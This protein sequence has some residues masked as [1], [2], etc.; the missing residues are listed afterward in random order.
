[1]S[2]YTPPVLY[3]ANHPQRETS[4]RCNRC[5]KPICPDCAVLTPTGYRCKECVRGMQKIY[6]TAT[7]IDFVLAFITALVLSYIGS[8]ITGFLGF[9]ILLLAPLVG[10]VIAEA[11]RYVIRKRRSPGLY[12]TAAIATALGSLP[13]LVMPVLT[14]IIGLSSS[15]AI[16]YVGGAGLSLIFK[17]IYT[18]LVTSSMYYRLTGSR[19]KL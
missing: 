14:L 5:E 12:L 19:L 10:I 4:L 3:C 7:S 6:N 2:E 11:V 9:F 1:M 15:N 18:I 8:L 16:S 13:G 17:V